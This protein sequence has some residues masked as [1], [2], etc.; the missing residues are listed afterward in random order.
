MINILEYKTYWEEMPQRDDRLKLVIF[1]TDESDLKRQLPDISPEPHY[2]AS[3]AKECRFII[4]SLRS[5]P[6]VSQRTGF[7]EATPPP[8]IHRVIVRLEPVQPLDEI[9]PLH[10]DLLIP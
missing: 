9:S 4:L 3:V 6:E 1:G 10:R 5:V 2:P 7:I 8:F